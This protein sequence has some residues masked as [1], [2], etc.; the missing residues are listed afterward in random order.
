MRGYNT[1]TYVLTTLV[2]IYLLFKRLKL[3]ELQWFLSGLHCN[4]ATFS[5]GMIMTG[6]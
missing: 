3:M 1:T 4:K 5:N 6:K 2:C